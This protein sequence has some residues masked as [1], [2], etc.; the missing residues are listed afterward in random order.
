MVFLNIKVEKLYFVELNWT[1]TEEFKPCLF[2]SVFALNGSTLTTDWIWQSGLC[3]SAPWHWL[4]DLDLFHSLKADRIQMQAGMCADFP[5]EVN[6]VEAVNV[7]LLSAPPLPPLPPQSG[8]AGSWKSP[9][10]SS[11]SAAHRWLCCHLHSGAG[12]LPLTTGMLPL[13]LAALLL[14]P[15]PQQTGSASTPTPIH[16]CFWTNPPAGICSLSWC[17]VWFWTNVCWVNGGSCRFMWGGGSFL[18][19]RW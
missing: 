16:W 10:P 18:S 14:T 17:S 6:K 2:S 5:H 12:G 15:P 3:G 8:A 19:Q 1:T 11:A 7:Y 4:T 9:F 13:L